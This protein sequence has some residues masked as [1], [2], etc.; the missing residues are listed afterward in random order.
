MNTISGESIQI[1]KNLKPT[2]LLF[3]QSKLTNLS[4]QYL[5]ALVGQH[6][7]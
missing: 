1:F 3:F 7:N 6:V 2:N 5:C 4:D